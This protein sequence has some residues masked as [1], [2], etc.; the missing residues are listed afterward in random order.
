MFTFVSRWHDDS[1]S[2]AATIDIRRRFSAALLRG[3]AV[4]PVV[5][6]YSI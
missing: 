4:R 5:D 2:I 3:L 6:I 1:R